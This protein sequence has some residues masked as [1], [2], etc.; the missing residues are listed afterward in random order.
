[1]NQDNPLEPFRGAIPLLRKFQD[2]PFWKEKR[3]FSHCEAL[4]DLLYKARYSSEEP[5][6][7]LDRGEEIIIYHAQLMTSQVTLAVEWNRSRTWVKKFI[8]YLIEKNTIKI[9]Q[10]N[11]RRLIIE[12]VN[13]RKVQELL[14]QYGQ[15]NKQYNEQQKDG[16]STYKNKEDKVNTANKDLNS[17]STSSKEEPT[18]GMTSLSSVLNNQSDFNRDT[19]I[20]TQFQEEATRYANDLHIN[21]NNPALKEKSFDKRWFKLFKDAQNDASLHRK[22]EK[23]Y[24]YLID[25]IS[26]NSANDEEKIRF[27]F[28]S[29]NGE[30]VF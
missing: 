26:F 2:H 24:S 6:P 28:W 18:T 12:I 3:K 10:M 13:M 21:I 16:K 4:I 8:N 25:H 11:N 5:T 1:M 29:L 27:F 17:G 15:Q 9:I 30:R 20:H 23:A 19:N 7:I 14:K 22:I